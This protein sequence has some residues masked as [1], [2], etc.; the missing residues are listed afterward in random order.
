MPTPAIAPVV[1]ELFI[2]EGDKASRVHRLFCTMNA[3]LPV[4]NWLQKHRPQLVA[5]G[6]ALLLA[7][8]GRLP[9]LAGYFARRRHE[10]TT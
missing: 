1:V 3:K 2:D 7:W 10:R 8:R 4:N 9:A 5:A 6:A